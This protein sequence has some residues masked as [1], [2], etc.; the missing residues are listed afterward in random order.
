[1]VTWGEGGGKVTI[2]VLNICV[3]SRYTKKHLG[4]NNNKKM[5]LA[6]SFQRFAKITL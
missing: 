6:N 5:C 1:M 4:W 2:S 3:K